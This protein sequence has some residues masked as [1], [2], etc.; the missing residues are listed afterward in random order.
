MNQINS[1]NNIKMSL[2]FSGINFSQILYLIKNLNHQIKANLLS[3]YSEFTF[4]IFKTDKKIV[5]CNV[6]KLSNYSDIYKA[7]KHFLEIFRGA[8]ILNTQVDNICA[9]L[10]LLKKIDLT[11]MFMKFNDI[12][13]NNFKVHYNN[14]K[15]PGM[16]IKFKKEFLNGTIIIFKSGKI[17]IIGLKSPSHFVEIYDWII[18]NV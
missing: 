11:K 2:N 6:T 14:Q 5:H 16:F 8:T 13:K 15:F 17:I 1:I 4:V 7:K 3:V 10:N 12:K 18:K 9:S